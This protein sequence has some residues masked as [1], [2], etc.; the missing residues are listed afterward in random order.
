MLVR[1]YFSST[2]GWDSVVSGLVMVGFHLLDTFSPKTTGKNCSLRA[3]IALFLITCSCLMY[4]VLI[5]VA[6]LGSTP[7]LKACLLGG[8][9]L[10]KCVKV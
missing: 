1:L 7:Q 4:S 3:C 5:R 6:T 10:Y 8:R 9:V 2:H